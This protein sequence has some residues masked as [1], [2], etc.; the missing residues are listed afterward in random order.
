M[1]ASYA[2]PRRFALPLAVGL[3][4]LSLTAC[5]SAADAT[6]GATVAIDQSALTATLY[7]AQS[8][9]RVSLAGTVH[10]DTD[11]RHMVNLAL[12]VE[13]T[14][15]AHDITPATISRASDGDVRF[16]AWLDVPR[17]SAEGS[18]A[19]QVRALDGEPF[20]IDAHASF[21][22]S[23]FRGPLALEA[24]LVSPAPHAGERA[25]W[26]LTLTNLASFSLDFDGAFAT[27][28]GWAS[29]VVAPPIQVVEPGLKAQYRLELTAPGSAPAGD[30]EWSAVVTSPSH[31]EISATLSAPFEV[32]RP[33]PVPGSPSPDL[34]ALYWLPITLGLAGVGLVLYFSLTEVGYLALSFSLLVPLFT[35]LRR[36]KVLDNFTRGQ[37]YGY[38]Q[39][40]PGAHYS[41]IQQVLDIENGVLAY[42]L[43][44]LLRENY[45][46]ARSEGIFKRFYPR[47]YKIPKGRTLLTRLQVDIL[48][49]AEQSPGISQREVARQLVESKQVI[50]YNVAVLRDAGLLATERRGR[51]VTLQ[52]PETAPTSISPPPV[53]TDP[54]V[55][56]PS[57]L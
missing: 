6:V 2:A 19:L 18:Y 46:V 55:S 54:G 31:P 7:N 1:R 29:R 15:W 40:N 14:S 53:G 44:V 49:A 8:D 22:V 43:R 26:T 45:L 27:P 33:A 51:D 10:I 56:D 42:H 21:T 47:D 30:Y 3:L 25:T 48:E 36:D 34:L 11:S 9:L 4:L 50:S 57:S 24:D 20:P 17:Q 13:G 32:I 39:A 37:I 35:R 28:S 23:V 52:A 41:A 16:T 12:S 38:I 5:A